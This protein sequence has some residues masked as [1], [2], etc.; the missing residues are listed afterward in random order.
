MSIDPRLFAQMRSLCADLHDDDGE[1]PRHVA[2]RRHRRRD[3]DTRT[4]QLCGQ[5]GRA[6]DLALGG[7]ADA[8]AGV[9]VHAVR[10]GA[11][12]QH[13]I[14]ELCHPRPTPALIAAVERARGW[15]RAEAA[16]AIH[17]KRVPELVVTLVPA[18]EVPR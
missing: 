6:L 5:I 17:R 13:L 1:D 12:P 9:T 10:P 14:V 15:L 7:R 16:A 2:R 3:N 4:R 11:D 18:P 8:L